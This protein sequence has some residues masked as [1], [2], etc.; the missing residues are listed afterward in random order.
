MTATPQ[1]AV[2]LPGELVNITTSPDTEPFWQAAKQDR[3]E[4]PKCG[5][6]GHFRMPPT[7]FCPECQSTEVEWT[8]LSGRA[9]VFSFA[10]VHGFPGLPDITMV[11]VVVDLEGAPGARLVSDVVDV[12]PE[13]V[14][15]GMELAVFFSPIADDWKLP[16]F[17][18]ARS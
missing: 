11:P 4:V 8:Q 14:H 7:P 17:R 10:V 1:L 6:C 16:L 12:A 13:D 9:T 18:V 15:I 3:L 5:Q 2:A